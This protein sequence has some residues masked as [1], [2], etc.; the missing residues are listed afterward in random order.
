M[1]AARELGGTGM[2]GG[3]GIA[4]TTAIGRDKVTGVGRHTT[5]QEEHT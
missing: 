4:P 5:G 3:T 2:R 1:P